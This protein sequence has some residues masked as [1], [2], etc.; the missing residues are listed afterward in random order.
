MQSDQAAAGTEKVA[1]AGTRARDRLLDLVRRSEARTPTSA[2]FFGLLAVAIGVRVWAMIAYGSAVFSPTAHDAAAYVGAAHYGLSYTLAEPS[3]YPVFLRATHLIS[4]SLGFTIGVQHV[5]GLA[6]GTLLFLSVQRLGVPAWLGLIPAAVVW[7]DG[8]QLF[9]EHTLL[10]DALFTFLVAAT[11]YSAVRSLQGGVVWTVLAGALAASTLAVRSVGVVVP[12][13]VIG[14]L[15]IIR[16]R[17]RTAWAR[18]GAIATVSAVVVI[19]A[20]GIVRHAGTGHWSILPPGSGWSLY[21]RT[22][23]FA[24]CHRFTPPRGTRALCESTPPASRQGPLYYMWVGG[25][26]VA[27]FGGTPQH[28]ELLKSFA[29]AAILHQPLDYLD[30][31][32]ADA[33]RYVV[34]GGRPNWIAD[35]NTTSVDGLDFPWH[36]RTVDAAVQRQIKGYYG[37]VATPSIASARPLHDYQRVFRVTGVMLLV[38][39][40]LG[41]TGLFVARGRPRYGAALLLAVAAGLLVFPAFA[42]KTDWRYAVPAIGPLGAAAAIGGWAACTTFMGVWSRARLR[43]TSGGRPAAEG[44]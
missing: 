23:E 13:I 44:G 2:I 30:T 39:F 34:P 35:S 17:S 15:V 22:A 29:T 43:R 41:V 33:R 14:W 8:D 36:G 5:L 38:F 16:L 4:H 21:A 1:S 42:V 31:V 11:L 26:G 18:A 28:D 19:G 7:F 25:P 10:S 24:D 37:Q 9:L 6:T 32:W 3:G 40:G 27:H 20:Y 12:V